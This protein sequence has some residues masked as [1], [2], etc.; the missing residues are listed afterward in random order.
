MDNQV[1]WRRSVKPP[2]LGDVLHVERIDGSTVMT[3]VILS[4]KPDQYITH[5]N[6]RKT[7]RCR[8]PKELCEGCQKL[9][10]TRWVGFLHCTNSELR[11][12]FALE[13]TPHAGHQCE[14]WLEEHSSLRGVLAV[15]TR[16]RKTKKSPLNLAFTGFMEGLEGLPPARSTEP[17]ALRLYG[18]MS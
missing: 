10:P 8:V 1:Q 12:N 18:F 6:G 16:L 4:E 3:C 5:W 9:M 13:L 17:T 11:G 2:P 14:A 15:V 7:I